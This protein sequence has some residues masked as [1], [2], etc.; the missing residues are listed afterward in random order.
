MSEA[1]VQFPVTCPECGREALLTRPLEAVV[2]TL[3]AGR[4][5]LPLYAPCHADHRTVSMPNASRSLSSVGVDA[6]G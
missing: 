6:E 5:R 2:D 4:T 3:V 1:T